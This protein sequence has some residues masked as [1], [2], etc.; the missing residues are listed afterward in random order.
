MSKIKPCV[1]F[2]SLQDEYMNGK[3]SLEDLFKFAA[4]N[5]IDGIEMLPDQMIHNAPHPTDQTLEA[6]DQMVS[7]Y[8]RTLVCEDVFLNTNLYKNR[9]LTKK[10][11]CDLIIE[12]IKLAHRLGFKLI[13]LVSMVPYYI[14]EPVLPYAEKYGVTLALEIHAGI[15]FDVKQTQDF[16]AE[17]KRLN[18]PF[19]G[20]VIDAGIFCRRAPRVMADY[21]KVFGLNPELPVYLNDIFKRGSD[22]RQVMIENNGGYPLELQQMMK[23]GI[24]HFFI[25]LSD[26]YENLPYT[27]LDEYMPYIKHF[28]F[29]LYEMTDEGEEYSIDY[30][31]LIEYL[32]D[33]GYEGYVSTEYEGNRWVLPGQ[34]IEEKKHVIAH[35]QMIRR[36]INEVEGKG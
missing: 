20:L 35:Q 26:G 2:Y 34:P 21:C 29:K 6:W 24:D 13:R 25:H 7:K 31:G 10:E 15:A 12:E 3:M 18:S 36:F 19:V 17:M 4:D 16:I 11:C 9:T 27:V 33:K 30:K 5:D 32:H 23:S 28:H 1:S 14:L 22:L 8:N